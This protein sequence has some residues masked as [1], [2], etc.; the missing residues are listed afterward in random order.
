MQ[1]IQRRILFG[2]TLF[3]MFFGA[4]NL[5]FPP[6]LGAQA[7]INAIPAF[8]G[9]A[10]SAICLPVLGVIAITLSGGVE[11]LAERVHPQFSRFYTML[12]YLS[13]GPFLAIPRTASTSFSM[14]VLPHLEGSESFAQLLYSLLFFA[15]AACVALHP[16]KLTDY[17]GKRLSP[18][19]LALIAVLFV[20]T[21]LQGIPSVGTAHELYQNHSAVQGFI[22]GYQTMDAIAA[23]NF[24]IVIAMNI[25]AKGIEK[26][27]DVLRETLHTGWIAGVFLLVV[28]AALTFIGYS[29]GARYGSG[30]NGTETLI[31]ATVHLFGS[32]GMIL[33]AIVFVIAC[34]N[35]CVGL[36]SCCSR[37]FYSH[38][39]R[40]GYRGLLAV[41]AVSSMIISNV[42]LN[43]ILSVSVP[44]LGAIYPVSIVLI[45]LSLLHRR[46][47]AFPSIYPFAVG[48]TG[49]VSVLSAAESFGLFLPF[50]YYIPLYDKGFGWILPALLGIAAGIALDLIYRKKG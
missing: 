36:L 25:R 39:P 28:Y 18:I 35:T 10:A 17:L 44:I 13:I 16:E 32:A 49:V 37:Y 8:I 12:L 22:D 48:F 38:F 21:A 3:S 46:I 42:G 20:S 26:D 50:L 15:V 45:L 31:S 29:A 14:A 4:G 7:G 19:L 23:L 30:A 24:G 2:I 41:F 11:M 33:L 1:K 5:I 40:I 34:F 27:S 6:F 9:F 47:A 43:T